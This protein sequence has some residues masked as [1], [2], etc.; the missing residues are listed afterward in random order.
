MPS[1]RPEL[2]AW[3]G[4]LPL[5]LLA[6]CATTPD[7]DW[8]S[9]LAQ[10]LAVDLAR[11]AN[12]PIALP[13][14][15]D[16]VVGDRVCY[17]VTLHDG[18]QRRTWQL[19]LAIANVVVERLQTWRAMAEFELRLQPDEERRRVRDAAAARAEPFDF[20]QWARTTE[21]D[22]AVA[23]LVVA[24]FDGAGRNLGSAESALRVWF[25][26]EGLLPACRAGHRR[27]D[28][29]RGRVAAGERAPMLTVDEATRADVATV[30]SGVDLC[31][32]LFRVLRSN[33]VTKQIL[34]EVLALPSWWSM[35]TNW[36]VRI[37][38]EVDFFAVERIA[39]GTIAGES[40]ELWSVPVVLRLNDQP[41]FFASVIVGPSGSPDGAA[42]G[43]YGLVARHPHDERRR[44][45]VRM[46]S[47]R[48]KPVV[49]PA[50]AGK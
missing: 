17:E 10:R 25:L 49:A 27:R 19:E 11:G 26:R 48:R 15:A 36:G 13:A 38:F 47:A 30:A 34:W 46:L 29:M 7:A 14:D 41:G 21:R 50:A 4:V 18:D 24:A 8:Q 35:L 20:E 45:V 12:A 5:L 22:V 37:T 31:R 32:D 1:L 33:P 23:G 2:S 16:P 39:P 3:L 43:V 6:A 44:V 42:A 28:L 40:R 9:Q